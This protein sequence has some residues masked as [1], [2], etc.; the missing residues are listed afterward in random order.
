MDKRSGT[1]ALNH[2]TSKSLR[3]K[4]NSSP[5]I[6]VYVRMQLKLLNKIGNLLKL[7]KLL[8]RSNKELTS[9]TELQQI[10]DVRAIQ[11]KRV[12]ASE[13]KSNTEFLRN[14]HTIEV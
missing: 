13:T 2:S 6:L 5:Q 4:V 10:K 12:K 9:D 1:L 11:I 14:N 3:T 7:K 8:L